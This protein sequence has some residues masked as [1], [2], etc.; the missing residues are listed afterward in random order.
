MRSKTVGQ[1]ERKRKRL[2]AL[3][4]STKPKADSA[5]TLPVPAKRLANEIEAGSSFHCDCEWTFRSERSESNLPHERKR[6]VRSS[7]SV[8]ERS[9]RDE[10]RESTNV[11][12]A[13]ERAENDSRCIDVNLFDL[14]PSSASS[15]SPQVTSSALLP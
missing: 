13:L 7:A 4:A 15:P 6:S 10:T 14:Y 2:S 12:H 3:L 8:V 1:S 11:H 5:L 9:M